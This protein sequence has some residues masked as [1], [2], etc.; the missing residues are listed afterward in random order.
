VDLLVIL[1]VA[2]VAIAVNLVAAVGIGVAVAVLSFLARMS[3][4]LVRRTYHGDAIHSRRTRD[5]RLMEIL[6]A[7]GRKIAVFELEGPIFFGTAEDLANRV[8]AAVR[9]GVVF[10]VI[11]CKRINEIDSTGARILLQI[12][13]RLARAG[14]HLLVSHL[15][16]NERLADFLSAMGVT[17]ALTPGRVF[18]DTDRALEWAED[19]LIAA[20]LGAAD[21]GSERGL[22]QL[23][24]MAG[25]SPAEHG[26]LRDALVRRTYERGDTVIREGETG[27]ELFIIARGTASVTLK[28]AGKRRANRL[29][30]FSVGT[31]FGEVALLDEQP[32]SATVEADEDLVCYVLTDAAFEWLAREHQPIAIKLL[33]NLGRELSRR[34]RRANQTIYEMER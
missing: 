29:A 21:A 7:H 15:E 33:K 3:R 6:Q 30:T 4:S 13:E 2:T 32:R 12:H 22:D 14:K 1:L 27:R 16:A 20:E 17:A 19:R 25:L 8:E 26:V 28:L 23:D 34:L 5:P 18:G 10:V 11:D 9:D 24:A 31:V